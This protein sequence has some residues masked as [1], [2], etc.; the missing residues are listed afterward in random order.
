VSA[1]CWKSDVNRAE[2]DALRKSRLASI[3]RG[4]RDEENVPANCL[5]EVTDAKGG[6]VKAS[7]DVQGVAT[8]TYDLTQYLSKYIQK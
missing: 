6:G 4:D 8:I 1:K 5:A 7:S 3:L 2:V